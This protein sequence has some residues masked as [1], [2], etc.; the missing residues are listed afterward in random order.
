MNG[1]LLAGTR[2]EA[3][4]RKRLL[5][6]GPT[7]A[8]VISSHM[9]SHN[10]RPPPRPTSPDGRALD[11]YRPVAIPIAT[12]IRAVGKDVEREKAVRFSAG[13]A[14]LKGGES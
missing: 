12:E 6:S 8:T 2:C 3:T 14:A 1:W 9:Q 13:R 11:F 4:R 10:Q 7:F 5:R